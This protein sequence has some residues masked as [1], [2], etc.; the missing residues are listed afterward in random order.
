MAE[1]FWHVNVAALPAQLSPVSPWC[2]DSRRHYHA[3]CWKGLQCSVQSCFLQPNSEKIQERDF[4]Q[5]K[6]FVSWSSDSAQKHFYGNVQ[7]SGSAQHFYSQKTPA[8]RTPGHDSE[9]VKHVLRSTGMFVRN[10]E[11]SWPWTGLFVGQLGLSF[12]LAHTVLLRANPEMEI[13]SAKR[14]KFKT[15]NTFDLPKCAHANRHT[16]TKQTFVICRIESG[17]PK[18]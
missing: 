13:F 10:S 4:D 12:C 9:H 8:W 17:S 7:L 15:R 16:W 3:R 1:G 6:H 2:A 14:L 5:A 11:N 18:M